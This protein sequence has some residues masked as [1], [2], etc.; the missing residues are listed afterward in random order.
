MTLDDRHHQ[1]V[2]G[3]A[4]AFPLDPDPQL[5]RV[6]VHW[7]GGGIQYTRRFANEEEA[8]KWGER[9]ARRRPGAEVSVT[10]REG[11]VA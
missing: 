6:E 1:V 4:D 7:P 9:K 3:V 8:V 10:L 5:F 11:A 2:E